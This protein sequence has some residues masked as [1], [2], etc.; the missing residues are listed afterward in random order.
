MFTWANDCAGRDPVEWTVEFTTKDG[1]PAVF[2][3][4]AQTKKEP[5]RFDKE[6]FVLDQTIFAKSAKFTF[7]K[8][9]GNEGLLQINEIGFYVQNPECRKVD[10]LIKNSINLVSYHFELRKCFEELL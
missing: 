4:K 5:K 7:I 6:K 10:L 3:H 9:R 8:N 2:T 1:S